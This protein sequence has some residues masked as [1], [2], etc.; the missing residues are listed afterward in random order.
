MVILRL[1]LWHGVGTEVNHH[2]S[3]SWGW[4]HICLL[5]YDEGLNAIHI[6]QTHPHGFNL[7]KSWPVKVKIISD[8]FDSSTHA[9]KQR[10]STLH[11]KHHSVSCCISISWKYSSVEKQKSVRVSESFATNF[12]HFNFGVWQGKFQ[13]STSKYPF[14]SFNSD[15][16]ILKVL[17]LISSISISVSIP[18]APHQPLTTI[19]SPQKPISRQINNFNHFYSNE[20]SWM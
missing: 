13:I 20:Q 12:K 6:L 17:P 4:I 9:T 19:S 7:H 5:G 10:K 14:Q 3:Q 2:D 18:A 11:N 16:E 1:F 15:F 8:F